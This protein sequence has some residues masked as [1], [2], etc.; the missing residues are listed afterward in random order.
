MIIAFSPKQAAKWRPKTWPVRPATMEADMSNPFH[1]RLTRRTGIGLV[2]AAIA[3]R[4]TTPATAQTPAPD[5]DLPS[6][7]LGEQIRWLLDLLNGDPAAITEATVAEHLAPSLLEDTPAAD[8]ARTLSGIAAALDDVFVEV[9]TLALSRNQ[10]PTV[11]NFDI[12]DASDHRLR[13]HLVVEPDSGLITDLDFEGVEDLGVDTPT[14]SPVAEIPFPPGPLGEHALWFV[15]TL[16]AGPGT[17]TD[18]ALDAHVSPAYFEEHSR[19]DMLAALSELQA[20]GLTWEVDPTSVISTMDLPTTVTRFE[21][22][23]SDGSRLEVGMTL[24]RETEL[25]ATLV[26]GPVGTLG[27][28]P[29]A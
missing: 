6:G 26:F 23:G 5:P 20:S 24:D 13:V 15:E 19:E 22:I 10:P 28:T 7:P 17:L 29:E 14:A 16:N 9:E 1:H 12:A 21:L 18:E 2:A 27:G 4:A 25:L 3:A 8:I 11:A